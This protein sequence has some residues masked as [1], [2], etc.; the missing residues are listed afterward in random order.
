MADRPSALLDGAL[1]GSNRDLAR[2]I[3]A[4]ERDL[5]GSL[6]LLDRVAGRDAAPVLGITGPPGCGKS[7][8]VDGLTAAWRARGAR[9][10]VLAVDPSSPFSGG[11]LLGDRI[12]MQ[13]HATDP[14]VFIRSLGSRGHQGGLTRSSRPIIEL[15]R[16]CAFDQVVVETAG[17]GQTEL[18][19][20]GLADTVAVVLVPGSGDAIQAM[21]AGLMEIADV[22]VVNKADLSGAHELAAVLTGA[23][24]R[25]PPPGAGAGTPAPPVPV[26]T[27]SALHRRGLDSLLDALAEVR[28]APRAPR[29]ARDARAETL[30]LLEEALASHL[31]RATSGG[32]GPRGERLAAAAAGSL[33]PYRAAREVLD[34]HRILDALL[35]APRETR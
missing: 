18:Q 30:D 4:I 20:A 25:G 7:T 13:R 34:D 35:R 14:G 10:G 33:S 5:E 12:R 8:L 6:G 26:V 15:M 3:S 2:L 32:G 19:V 16:R 1:A 23:A 11:A 17:V 22:V 28:A 31:R 24:L 27:V 29:R 21:K 9:V